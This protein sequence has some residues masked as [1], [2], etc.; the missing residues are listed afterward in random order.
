MS[1]RNVQVAARGA[2]RTLEGIIA[3]AGEQ[4]TGEITAPGVPTGRHRT[5]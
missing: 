2:N 3:Q 1:S 4:P 5:G